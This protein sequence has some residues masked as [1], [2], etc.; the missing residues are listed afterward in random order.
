MIRPAPVPRRLRARLTATCRSLI[1]RGSM[2]RMVLRICGEP[3]LFHA[4]VLMEQLYDAPE[5]GKP[6]HTDDRGKND[7]GDQEGTAEQK[8][9]GRQKD[10]PAPVRETVFRFDHDGVEYADAQ[11]RGQSQQDTGNIHV[12]TAFKD[13]IR[14]DPAQG[15]ASSIA[16][17]G[18]RIKGFSIIGPA[19]RLMR[20]FSG[21]F[22]LL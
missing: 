18:V 9:P 16:R 20:N 12:I 6:D 21:R 3:S 22:D 1:P 19:M 5:A 4:P 10:R 13:I 2:A 17:I 8:E 14:P 15:P 11:K 7:V